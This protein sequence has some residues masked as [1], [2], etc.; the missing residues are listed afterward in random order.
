MDRQKTT[1][2]RQTDRQT[3]DCG[4]TDG[5]TGDGQTDCDGQMVTDG[6][7]DRQ[8]VMD[9]QWQIDGQSQQV[10][11]WTDGDRC[12]LTAMDR[13]RDGDRGDRR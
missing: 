8:M 13:W 10:D 5:R 6:W 2:G 7:T 4:L 11:G 12:K 1:D 9:R 3:R